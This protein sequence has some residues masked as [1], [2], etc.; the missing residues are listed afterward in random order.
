MRPLTDKV[1]FVTGGA[2]GI[3]YETARSFLRRGMKVMLADVEK[4]PLEKAAISLS[5]EGTVDAMTLDVRDRASLFAAATKT[6]E[7]FGKVHVVFNN[8]GVGAGGPKFEDIS[9][10]DWNWVVDVNLMGVVWGTQA[11]LPHIRAQ[12]EGGHIVN[13]ASMAG[14][15]APVGMSPYIA[16]KFAV[17]GLTESLH[18][19]LSGTGIGASVLCPGF[20]KTRIHESG[21]NKPHKDTPDAAGDT[22]Q[23]SAAALVEAGIDPSIIGERVV[24]AIENDELYIFSHPDYRPVLAMRLETILNAY[25]GLQKSPTLRAAGMVQG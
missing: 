10:A 16:T 5:N 13:T 23:S 8:A 19:E 14:M 20:V 22:L 6:I 12:N 25:D 3:G 17:V 9:A 1:A 15:I 24:E 11:F 7:R 2:S 18:A 21:R 4:A